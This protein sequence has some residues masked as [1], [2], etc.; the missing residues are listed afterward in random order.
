M[1]DT[2]AH[3]RFGD[4]CIETLPEY[5]N[6]IINKNRDIY[7]FGVHGPDIFFYHKVYKFNY[8]NQYGYD[9]HEIPYDE[10]LKKMASNFKQRV[11]DKEAALAYILGFT[12]HFT[13][14]SY[15]H[16]YIER[17]E[18]VSK[19]TTKPLSHGRIESQFDKY[20]MIKDGLNPYKNS[21]SKTLRPNKDIAKTISEVLPIWD[22]KTIYKTIKDQSTYVGLLHD[23]NGFKRWLIGTTLD[24][25]KAPKYKDLMFTKNSYP[26]VEDALI[27]L[28]KLFDKALEHYPNLAAN[29]IDYIEKGSSLPQYFKNHF[30]FKKN[31]KDIPVLTLDA[32]KRY[33]VETQE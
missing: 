14:D 11:E 26:E 25:F 27:R 28:D 19:T 13:L 33:E 9:L 2:Y 20:L 8:V 17:K 10:T 31:Y 5:Y 3:W 32:E 1:P 16:S 7:N 29:V 21:P 6:E 12:A 24:I 4:K 23:S 22:E 30:S 18:E 15:C